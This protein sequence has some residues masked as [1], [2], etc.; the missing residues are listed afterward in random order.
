VKDFLAIFIL[1]LFSRLPFS[2]GQKLGA[3]LGYILWRLNTRARQVT[4]KNIALCFPELSAVQQEQLIKQSL[5]ECGKNIVEM[6][7]SW[8]WPEERVRGLVKKVSGKELVESALTKNKGVIILAPHLGNWEILGLY[9]TQLH[10]TTFLYQ[11]PKL[12]K[13]DRLIR[14]A[15]SRS[16]AN[17]VPTNRR[18]VMA[19]LKALKAGEMVGI[20]PDQE[21]DSASG[22]FAP[23]FGVPA[24]SMTL[25]SNLETK[26]G[27]T[28]ICSY[29]KR[30]PNSEGFEIVFKAADEQIVSS[31]IDESVAGLN[32]SV[33]N[34]VNDCRA[35]YQ[36]E[37]K[38]F[39]RRPNSE[40]R[41]Y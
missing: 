3:F 7:P 18:G 12:P 39:K 34:V 33:E 30:L 24:L 23:F 14:N 36:W 32:H 35:Q 9:L 37:Y 1:K 13:M 5:F 22:V 20:L 27:A 29:A 8:L 2:W 10:K 21:P 19:L 25:I 15:R 4:E 26:T 41:F 11:P 38:R 31:D 17:I 6:G 40:A 16:G 28:V